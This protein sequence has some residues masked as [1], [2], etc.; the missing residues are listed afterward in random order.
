MDLSF[1]RN[2][3]TRFAS[4]SAAR[5]DYRVLVATLEALQSSTATA[6]SIR[7]LGAEGETD[8]INDGLVEL[9]LGGGGW[10]E[11]IVAQRGSFNPRCAQRLRE[12]G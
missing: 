6:R 3:Q 11:A 8:P 7:G 10:R 9:I 2:A 12:R 4:R 1:F 5:L